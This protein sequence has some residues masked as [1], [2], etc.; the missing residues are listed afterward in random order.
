MKQQPLLLD[1]WRLVAAAIATFFLFSLLLVQFFKVQIIEEEKWRTRAEAQHT[2]VVTEPFKRGR[3][4]AN[5]SI[6]SSHQEEAQPL[7]MDVQRFHLFVDPY[8]IKEPVREEVANSLAELLEGNAESFLEQLARAR[9]RSRRLQRWLSHADRDAIR[10]WWYPFARE[11]KLA[12][13]A[14]FFVKDY[15]RL[16]PYGA[17]AGQVLHTIQDQKDDKTKRALP[18]GGLESSLNPYL[19]G[20]LGSKRM[21]RS[22][23]NRFST[24]EV[25]QEPVDGAD[26]YLT[27]N[28]TLQAI[29]EK[30]L[31][32]GIATTQAHAGWA[33]MMDPFTGEILALAQAPLFEPGRY[34]DF[35]NDPKLVEH[36]NV[37]A[38]TDAQEPGSVMKPITIAVAL[39]ANDVLT[40]RGEAPLFDPTEEI[41]VS[42]GRFPGRSRPIT[43]THPMDTLN[44]VGGMRYS[45]NIYMGRLMQRVVERMGNQWYRDVLSEIFGF[46]QLTGIELP[47]ETKGLLP[48][49]GKMHPNGRLEWSKPTP[50]SLAMGYNLQASSLQVLRAWAV[51]ANGG[52]L[53]QP[54]LVKTIERGPERLLDHTTR[55]PQRVLP[56]ELTESVRQALEQVTKEGGTGRRGNVPGFTEAGKTGTTKK[57]VDGKYSTKKY[58]ASFV[59][60]V[61]AAQP[62]FLLLVGID[63]PPPSATGNQYG[64]KSAAPVFQRIASRTLEYLGVR[65]DDAG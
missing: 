8:S 13:N 44:M 16:Y 52:H 5:G 54:T 35:F 23:R 32:E 10:E 59:G 51:I 25:L 38:A 20:A 58:Y 64:G 34:R 3:F 11:H 46:G 6:R 17:L 22:P 49:L 42:S 45:S 47:T 1:R 9:S 60:F 53:V 24:G 37:R 18:T 41:D 28:Q 39:H 36:T 2:F 40:S 4:F 31:V 55:T 21:L 63:E 50:Y 57:L 7:V 62:R 14:L 29:A 26:V 15:Q 65:P 30:E 12:R 33:V 43:D 27:I 56:Q 48:R 19:K 61:P